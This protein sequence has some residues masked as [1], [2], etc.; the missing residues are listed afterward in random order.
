MSKIFYHA[1]NIGGLKNLLPLSIQHGGDEKV[2]YF[3]LFRAYALFYLRDIEINHI[4]CSISNEGVTTYYEEFLNQL[5]VIYG[6]RSGYLYACENNTEITA[7]HTKG[8][9]VAKQ[10][11]FP[12]SSEY[13]VDVYAEILKFEKKGEIRVIRYESLPDDK[14]AEII[15]KWKGII[16][17]NN[18][19]I[20][21]TQ[22]SRFYAK[23]FPQAWELAIKTTLN[24]AIQTMTSEIVSILADNKPTIY[25]FGSVVLDDFKLGWSDIDIVVLTEREIPEQQAETLVGLRQNML[26]RY[27]GNPYFRLFEGGMLSADAFLNNRT[28][29]TIYWGTSGQRITDNYKLDSFGTA[30]LLD[31]GILI[32]GDDV[33]GKMKYP[34]YAQM[35]DDIA[36]HIE[37]VREHGSSVGWLLD[38]ARGI[39]TL[40]TG[41]VI[42]KTAAGEWALENEL[43]PDVEAMEKAVSIRKEPTQYSK[44]D[45]LVD[46]A[47]VLRFADVI[48]NE[49]VNTIKRFAESELQHMN[50]IFNTLSLIRN[51][52]GVSVW[53]VATNTDSYVM[54]C[55]DKTEYR[56]EITNYQLLN[57]LGVPTLKVIAN[58]D[59]SI[60]IEDI[61]RS[62]YRLGT[63]DDMNDPNV[64]K[65]I[66]AWYKTLHNNGRKYAN[67]H[68]FI[69]EF[70]RLTID[71]IKMV[72]S[73]TG[74]EGLR[75]WQV[76]EDNFEQIISS[77]MELPRTLAYTDFHYSNLSVA[78][79]GSSALIFDYNFFYK[80][81]VYSDI[82]NIC[83]SLSEES[84]AAFLSVYG[85]YDERE[86]IIDDVADTLSGIVM[87]CQ[88]KNFPKLAKNI[89]ESIND[90]RLLVAVGKLLE[91]RRT[92][93]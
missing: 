44:E 81:Y 83:W 92:S 73:K 43:C 46:K 8:V 34:T 57:S 78:R 60:I 93:K 65:L 17:K 42:A 9:W 30:E 12:S 70:Y 79:D 86:V 2:C 41:N 49:F 1:S 51:K 52:D 3:T 13:I 28:E 54:K 22:K 67:T 53:R 14:K 4:T 6:G 39:Y 82:R 35:R 5:K 24:E 20:L 55:F 27:P 89:A 36:R 56:C 16:I 11:V 37:T 19:F 59:C 68:D 71:N 48:D 90:E 88:R 91:K 38:I 23:S 72:Q 32:Y 25:L 66:A 77:I 47:V 85:G 64:A 50:I 31:K 74:T 58:T 75:V 33:R 18:L 80:S 76:I 69:D 63:A 61:E 7:G 10:T 62:E 40:R 29:R 84:K 21:N 26:E 87:D 45:K 15:E